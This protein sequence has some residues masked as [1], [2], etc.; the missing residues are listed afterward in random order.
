MIRQNTTEAKQAGNNLTVIKHDSTARAH[1]ST[2]IA[3]DR[4]T[5]LSQSV[6]NRSQISILYMN[7][8]SLLPKRDEILAYVAMEKPDVIAITETWI[9][10]DYLM[11]EYSVTGYESFH[12]N[13]AHTKGGGGIC[14]I[15]NTLIA[16]IIEK[17]DADI[18]D[19]VYVDITTERYRKLTFGTVYR[20][21]KLQA[22][23]DTALYEEAVIVG[24]FNCPNVD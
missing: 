20:P 19:S 3:H 16:V 11:S 14:Y 9:K 4:Q 15:K 12:K 7:A 6:E 5:T 22:A 1:D 18:Y 24:D 13:R 8:R 2:E 23:D 10:P 17:Q 21:P